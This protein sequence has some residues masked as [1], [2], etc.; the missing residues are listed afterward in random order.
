[1]PNKRDITAPKKE[2]RTPFCS[3]AACRLGLNP[4]G[5]GSYMPD[6]IMLIET[7]LPWP[8]GYLREPGTLPPEVIELARSLIYERP[9]G[10]P[11]RHR[12]LA[13]APDADYSRPGYRRLIYYR[14]PEG[15][16][17]DFSQVE[18]Q[19]PTA[20]VG[21]LAWAL[22]QEPDQLPT[23]DRYRQETHTRDLLVCTH[24]AVDAAC[25]KFGY[26]L[27]RTLRDQYATPSDGQ[28]RVWRV[29][30]IGGHL[31]APTMLEMPG[32]RYWGFLGET[33]AEQV[34][35]RSGDPV[36][37]RD[38]Y[39]GW[40][41]LQGPFLQVAERELFMQ[42]GWDWLDYH[43]S[44]RIVAPDE[45]GA[46]GQD[47]PTRP[48]AEVRIDFAS[49]DGQV[50]GTYEARVEVE[51]TLAAPPRTGSAETYPYPQYVVTQA[52]FIPTAAYRLTPQPLLQTMAT[53]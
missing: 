20:D 53:T 42:F 3:V 29:S 10:T 15:L 6:H 18:Y 23:F 27:Y 39:R 35:R 48:W 26:P 2:N 4:G 13:I 24:G 44:G 41:G 40:C 50:Q 51:C 37:L 17:A 46:N 36:R 38:N 14:R 9:T 25:S 16:F 1:M 8:R 34:A 12:F 47:D 28:L 5:Y 22:L 19:V 21:P 43:K 31:F 30:H 11:L 7:P 33:E 49:P 32:G 45:G 52:R